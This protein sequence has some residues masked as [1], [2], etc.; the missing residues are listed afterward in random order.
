MLIL[1]AESGDAA[2]ALAA[3]ALVRDNVTTEALEAHLLQAGSDG[4]PFLHVAAEKGLLENAALVAGVRALDG[5]ILNSALAAADKVRAVEP[6]CGRAPPCWLPPFAVLRVRGDRRAAGPFVC[7]SSRQVQQA[8]LPV[9]VN[10]V[11]ACRVSHAGR[12][13]V[14]SRTAKPSLTSWGQAN[15]PRFWLGSLA[16][17]PCRNSSYSRRTTRLD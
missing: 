16:R 12:R 11:P 15:C 8:M 3:L 5:A 2:A 10:N 6:A 14:W 13:V 4:K 9:C 17:I 7:A 1:A